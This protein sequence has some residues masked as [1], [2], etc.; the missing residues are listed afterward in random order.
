VTASIQ[1][2]RA[3]VSATIPLTDYINGETFQATVDF[4]WTVT[5]APTPFHLNPAP[6]GSPKSHYIGTS[7]TAIA[8]GSLTIS[9]PEGSY[10]PTPVDLVFGQ[11]PT[12]AAFVRG[13]LHDVS[14]P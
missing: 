5:G 9:G 14:S 1:G 7:R 4:S 12:Y 3:Q 10:F 2:G 13:I 8:T 6:G 11:T